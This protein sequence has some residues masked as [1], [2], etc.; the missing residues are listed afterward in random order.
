MQ[1]FMLY[2]NIMCFH[3]DSDE[4]EDGA[5][6][7]TDR[8]KKRKFDALLACLPE[9]IKEAWEEVLQTQWPWLAV[10][11]ASAFTMNVM[12]KRDSMAEVCDKN[13]H[14]MLS[15]LLSLPF[16]SLELLSSGC[17]AEANKLKGSSYKQQV[18]AKI[19][20]EA[21]ERDADG[22][23]VVANDKTGLFQEKGCMIQFKLLASV[24]GLLQGV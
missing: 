5:G 1:H 8:V 6:R 24:L 11:D 15:Q 20:N 16:L 4:G 19:V 9:V 18:K 21:I 13:N 3:Q 23:L 12:C 22:K 2:A 14:S 17:T 10:L 7:L